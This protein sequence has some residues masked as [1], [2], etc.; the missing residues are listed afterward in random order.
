MDVSSDRSEGY[1]PGM[2]D[3]MILAWTV[4]V[5]NTPI[6]PLEAATRLAAVSL[7][8]PVGSPGTPT[9]D[10]VLGQ[11]F[12]LTVAS[13]NT[14]SDATSA[15]RTLTLNMTPPN[16]PPPFPCHP[17]TS[18]PPL[19]D[20]PYPLVESVTLPGSF[21][22]QLG[23]MNVPTTVSQIPSL[24]IGDNV[25][26][27]SQ[28]GVFYA[29]ASIGPTSINLSSAYTGTTENTSAF[30]QVPAPATI[31]AMYSTSEL[32][33]DGVATVPAIAAGPG[34]RTVSISYVD[35]NGGS[36][37]ATCTLT[38]KRPAA[39]VLEA[40]QPIAEVVGV[41]IAS[42]GGFGNSVGQITLV[43]LSSAL[44]TLPTDLP[45]G[46]G[47]GPSQTP[48]GKVGAPLP[49][50]FK[51]MT[52]EA[53]LLINRH[54]V[55]LPPSYFAL[56]QQM[57]AMPM[58]TG[59]FI[60]TTG[61]ADVPTTEDQTSFITAGDFIEFVAQ[62]GTIYTILQV[63]P[64]I[65]T[66]ASVYTGIDTT[67]TPVENAGTNTNAGTKGNLGDKVIKMPTGAKSTSVAAS[68]PS[69]DLLSAPLGQFME[70][71]V[72]APPLNPPLIPSTVP[73]PTFLSGLYT[74]TL[75]LALA[76]IPITSATITFA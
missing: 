60:V 54:L 57:L 50:T 49:R 71:Q 18:T 64:K 56:A 26:F 20:S 33:T 46:T 63:T 7:Y 73:V 15:T 45:L 41:A 51:T 8:L 31:C 12:G 23:L 48:I 17:I 75:S 40:S 38:G 29:V 25:Q 9:T 4:D 52:D 6:G 13:D 34:A 42:V 14:T 58:L 68:A 61:S 24:S 22:P 27:L 55:Y 53:Q 67:H 21:F 43:E 19:L 47:I 36:R 10:P 62:P 70:T 32:D 28:E 72:A 69:S 3:Q 59:D 1:P 37:T 76:G 5:A 35:P 39:V 30:K 74:R 2:S 11:A 65:V 44:P 66:L 16:A